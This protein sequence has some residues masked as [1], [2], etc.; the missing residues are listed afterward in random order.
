MQ[1]LNNP[2]SISFLKIT[3]KGEKIV[4]NNWQVPRNKR[5]LYPV[6]EVL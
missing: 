5:K 6:V 2:T 3:S 4:I 1:A